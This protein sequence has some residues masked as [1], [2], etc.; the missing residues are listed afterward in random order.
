MAVLDFSKA[1]DTDSHSIPL[2]T[3]SSTQ[4]DKSIK[5]WVSN[6]LT[7]WA[8]RGIVNG[9]TSR[10][11]PV[12]SG[13][14]Q[15]SVLGTALLNIFIN[16]SDAGV[17]CTL[18]KSAADTKLEGAVD[19][20]KGR[21]AL[22]RDLDRPESWAIT[23]HMKFNKCHILHLRRRNPG[24]TYKP[25]EE[26]LESSPAERDLVVWVGGK[27]SA[28]CPGSQKSQPCLGVHQVRHSQPV[29]GGD[30]PTLL[31]SGA[32]PP[33]ALCA[34][35]GASVLAGHQVVQA[36]TQEGN[37]DGER[38]QGQDLG[39]AAEVTWFAHLGMEKAEA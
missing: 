34:V 36:C 39:A 27:E 15:G 5:R 2:D 10:W 7:G 3:M 8:Q 14:P 31:C 35:L 29:E 22:Q 24:F 21:K 19:S 9:V 32:A 1:F 33:Q 23:N 28:V 26:R 38:S 17:E 4:S 20:L 37:Q 13:V 25:G 16:D 30:W 6:W 18:S 12:T 11:W